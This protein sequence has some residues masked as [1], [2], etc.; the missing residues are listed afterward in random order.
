M[1]VKTVLI[2]STA[3]SYEDFGDEVIV[4]YLETGL[5]FSLNQSGTQIWR[6]LEEGI[7]LDELISKIPQVFRDPPLGFASDVKT[8]L[9]H[10]HEYQ[11]I[12]MKDSLSD[13][14][15]TNLTTTETTKIVYEAPKLECYADMQHLL[16]LDPIHEVGEDGWPIVTKN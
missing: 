1:D 5:Y 8:F 12:I 10:L 11:L 14:L 6:F 13:E 7:S 2:N 15:A 16:V 3:I 4:V 9:D